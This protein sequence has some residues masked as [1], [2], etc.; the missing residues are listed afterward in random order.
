M[1]IIAHKHPLTPA[2]TGIK[3]YL[4]KKYLDVNKLLSLLYYVYQN[5]KNAVLRTT[6]LSKVHQRL[7]N[8]INC[9]KGITKEFV[10]KCL[11]MQKCQNGSLPVG[12]RLYKQI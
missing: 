3:K 5:I 1:A 4:S 6:N 7:R 2:N 10:K 8:W 11:K 9:I 12:R